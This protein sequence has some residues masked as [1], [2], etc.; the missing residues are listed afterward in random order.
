MRPVHP[1]EVLRETLGLSANWSTGGW[2][3]GRGRC[4]SI[5]HGGAGGA[6]KGGETAV[7]RVTKFLFRWTAGG[8]RGCAMDG[9]DL[10]MVAIVLAVLGVS[11]A[12][13]LIYLAVTRRRQ[14]Q[15]TPL[16]ELRRR[17]R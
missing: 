3:D 4:E 14:Q 1:G 17:R 6:D 5:S 11:V 2:R 8:S 13:V 10:V 15:L 9:P 12:G 16:M 7:G